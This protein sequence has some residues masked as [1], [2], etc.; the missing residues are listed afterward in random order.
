M[1]A[2]SA[3]N[4]PGGSQPA[5]G[6]A[7]ELVLATPR[8]PKVRGLQ[9]KLWAAAKRSPNRRF[10]ALYDRIFRGDVL[11]EAWKRVRA[12]K[13]AAGIDGV[14]LAAVEEYGA[15]RLLAELQRDLREGSYRPAP[16]RRVDIPKPDGKT[17]PLGIPTVR[18]RIAQQAARLVIEPIFEA[19]F[20]DSSFGFRPKRSATDACEE[21]RKGFIDGRVWAFEADI[22]DCFGQIDHG[23]L[24]DALAGRISD[25]RVL[26]LCRK[27]LVAG[28]LDEGRY[29]QTVAGTPQGGVMTAPT[30]S[31]TSSL[32]GRFVALAGGVCREV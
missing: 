28:V 1:T 9:R 23:L 8:R 12:N 2:T 32:S 26:K 16:T 21:L 20:S 24:M 13:G 17:R 19:D 31:R 22:R 4:D 10:H 27:W 25:R 5:D 29:R 14:T 7:S 6:E 30:Q 18:D 15:E 3:V 11:E